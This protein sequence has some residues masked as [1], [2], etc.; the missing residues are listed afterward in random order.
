VLSLALLTA[1][2]A[3]V[4]G[5]SPGSPATAVAGPLPASA[6]VAGPSAS[7]SPRPVPTVTPSV[8]A[9]WGSKGSGLGQFDNPVSIAVGP[10]DVVYVKDAHTHRVQKFTAAGTFVTAFGKPRTNAYGD[11]ELGGLCHL[12][13]GRDGEVYVLDTASGCVQVFSSDGVFVRR[14]GS[15]GKADDQFGAAY[16]IAVDTQGRVYVGDRDKDRVC[17]FG[18]SGSLVDQWKDIGTGAD[19]FKDF[20]GIAI[21]KGGPQDGVYLLEGC[22][23]KL[24]TPAGDLVR[25]WGSLGPEPG[26]LAGP[27]AIAVDRP[28]FVYVSDNNNSRFQVFTRNGDVVALWRFNEPGYIYGLAVGSDA[29]VYA[30]DYFQNWVRRYA[31]VVGADTTPPVTTVKGVDDKWHNRAVTLSFSAT[32]NEGGSGVDRTEARKWGYYDSSEEYVDDWGRVSTGSSLTVTADSGEHELD[33]RRRVEFRSV[34]VAGN[35][36]STQTVTVLI[37]TEAPVTRILSVKASTVERRDKVVVRVWVSEELSAKVRFDLALYS[38]QKDEL[39]LSKKTG[40][41]KRKRELPYTWSFSGA[42]EPGRY[43]VIAAATDLAGN[44]GEPAAGQFLVK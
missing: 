40:W 25:R 43:T 19:Q 44:A 10:Q 32:D 3:V 30:V 42:L 13:V 35:E 27:Y 37:D 8:L 39:V 20:T 24:Y 17:V 6:H 23:V 29:S 9:Q 26:Q 33:G 4:V 7:E 22:E 21:A 15:N 2:V 12:A 34:D 18:P 38:G 28:G 36:E 16:G 14:W 41:V 31:P 11:G 1:A 5:A